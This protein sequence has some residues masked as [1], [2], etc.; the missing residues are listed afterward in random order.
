MSVQNV[1]DRPTS[2]SIAICTFN[3]DP[4]LLRRLL[5]SVADLEEFDKIAE[6]LIID[7][8]SRPSIRSHDFVGSFLAQVPVARLIEEPTIGLTAARCRAIKETSSDVVVLFDDDNEPDK[9]Y[10]YILHKYFSKYPNV[11]IWGPGQIQVE[12]VDPVSSW[13][14]R[15]QHR[16]H[17]RRRGFG[18]VCIPGAWTTYSPNGTGFAVRRSV[19]S[20]YV[21]AIELEKIRSPDRVGGALSSAGDVQLVWEAVKL[22]L[23]AG[24]VPELSCKHLINATKANPRY[25]R[26]LSFGTSSSYA[27]ALIESFPDQASQLQVRAGSIY[28]LARLARLLLKLLLRPPVRLEYQLQFASE[29]GAIYGRA[30]AIRSPSA[31]M[32][33]KLAYCLGL[34]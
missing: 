6:I 17:E 13:F 32:A 4:R 10:I 25:L 21:S 15:N 34:V 31:G 28:M 3:P 16:F 22:G 30:K 7:N 1:G 5:A 9:N 11:G 26:R 33:L 14:M 27:P 23:A 2:F 12:Y 24:M 19:L 20:A 29:L 18:Y 8:K